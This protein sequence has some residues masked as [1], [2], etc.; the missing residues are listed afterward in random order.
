MLLAAAMVSLLMTATVETQAAPS[1]E[2]NVKVQIN[3]ELVQFYDAGPYVDEENRLQVPVRYLTDKLGLSLDW[4]KAGEQ[5]KLTIAGKQKNITLTTGQSVALV[6]GQKVN[7][8]T[9]A[10]YKQGRVY[11]P[12]RF[13]S[14]A[15]GIRLQW[16]ADNRIAIMNEDGQYHAPAWYAQKYEKTLDMRATAYTASA[17]EN[18]SHAALDYF[19]NPLE[20]GTI[21]VDPSIIPLGSLVYIEGYNYDGLPEG[22]MVA[23]AADIGGSI[24]G[25]KIDI[26]VPGNRK[27]ALSFGVQNVKV[28]LMKQ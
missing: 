28:Y 26:F 23:K 15:L 4:Q 5:Y 19:G 17:A 21:S 18:G 9:G 22:G 6:N 16:D 3:D 1:Q 13:I 14:D 7:M 27:Q 24:K 8:D 12:F 25:N 2:D 10:N 11:V 20:V